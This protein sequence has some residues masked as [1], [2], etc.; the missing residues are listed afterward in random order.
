MNQKETEAE[1][2]IHKIEIIEKKEEKSEKSE[3]KKVP[4]II[5][6]VLEGIPSEETINGKGKN[7]KK[8][9]KK[10]DTENTERI[11]S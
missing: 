9:R 4:P 7:S 8:H 2:N 6:K 11:W 5:C 10:R 3:E 1:Q